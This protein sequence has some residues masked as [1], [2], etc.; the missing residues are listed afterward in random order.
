MLQNQEK[1]ADKSTDK[2]VDKSGEKASKT[3]TATLA[4]GCFWCTEAVFLRL[5][6]VQS[7]KSGYT[8][9]QV[10]NPTY[11][12]VCSGRTGHAEGIQIVY[13]P[14]V[15]TYKQLLDVFFHTHDPTT[16][17]RQG[18]DVGTQYRSAVFYHNDEQK[19]AA[20]LMIEEVNKSG[21]YDAPIVT[22]LEKFEKFYVAEEDHQNYFALNPNAS[23]CQ[24]VVGPKVEKFQKRYKALLKKEEDSSK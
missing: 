14:S 20:K 4:A 10:A 8:G 22:T 17:N 21:V 19:E 2:P 7:V 16:L 6:G 24:F 3:E 5:K 18:A 1:P 15:I 13:D 23:Y 12:Q 11:Q 9:G